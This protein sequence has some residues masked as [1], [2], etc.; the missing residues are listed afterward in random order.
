[1]FQKTK[2][3][4]KFL[5]Y[6]ASWIIKSVGTMPKASARKK[7]S[8]AEK[9]VSCDDV[10][11]AAVRDIIED[12]ANVNIEGDNIADGARV[13]VLLEDGKFGTGELS[14][15][16]ILMQKL[17]CIGSRILLS[18]FAKTVACKYSHGDED[19]LP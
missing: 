18:V 11:V 5:S 4:R 3:V 1:M 17:H 2:I 9:S 16:G 7:K 15:L 8:S 10:T 19:P 14:V 12:G 13:D 6:R